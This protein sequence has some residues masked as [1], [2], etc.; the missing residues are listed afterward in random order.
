MIEQALKVQSKDSV[1][2]EKVEQVT[3]IEDE[4]E[5]PRGHD[6][7]IL[8]SDFDKLFYSCDGCDFCL[9]TIKH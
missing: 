8:C 1:E 6:S 2:V 5:C 3:S 4:I 9:Y 7:M